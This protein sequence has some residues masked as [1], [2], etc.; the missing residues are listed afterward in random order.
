MTTKHPFFS[1]ADFFSFSFIFFSLGGILAGFLSFERKLE[2]EISHSSRSLYWLVPVRGSQVE[3]DEVGRFLSQLNGIKN[4]D[5]QSSEE[6]KQELQK[7]PLLRKELEGVSP[8]ALPM[9]WKINWESR[10]LSK[11]N[12]KKNTQE[13]LEFPGVLDVAFNVSAIENFRSFQ[14]LLTQFQIVASFSLVL[15]VLLFSFSLGNMFIRETYNKVPLKDIFKSAIFSFFG[16]GLGF[17]VSSMVF[18]ENVVH[19][20]ISFL[21]FFPVVLLVVINFNQKKLKSI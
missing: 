20:L 4:V 10:F 12:I 2:K 11:E 13:I 9:T 8:Q 3:I 19:Y 1:R 18:H 15:I 6:I 16:W 5:F 7:D 14:F 21:L 17:F